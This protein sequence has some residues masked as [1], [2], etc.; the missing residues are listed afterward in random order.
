M[1]KRITKLEEFV[2]GQSYEQ[3]TDMET[4]FLMELYEAVNL[5]VREGGKVSLMRMS[6]IVRVTPKELMDYL[7]EIIEMERQLTEGASFE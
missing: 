1:Q 4:D 6:T 3:I 5:I 2:A 7:P